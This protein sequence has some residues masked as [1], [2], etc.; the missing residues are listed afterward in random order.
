MTLEAGAEWKLPPASAGVNR[1]LYFY[2]GSSIQIADKNFSSHQAIE[3]DSEQEVILK[4]GDT[5]SHLLLLQGKPINEPV[6]QHGPFV[7]NTQGEIREAMTE[8]Q[9]T[10]FGGWPWSSYEHIHPRE[11]GRFALYPDGNEEVRPL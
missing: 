3:L 10:Q 4:N 2:S 5:I 8:Y 11:K 7:M 9:Q 1:S 6:V